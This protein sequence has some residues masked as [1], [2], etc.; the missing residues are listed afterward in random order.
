MGRDQLHLYRVAAGSC[1]EVWAALM[2]AVAWG[3]L[4]AIDLAVAEDLLDLE[5]A[6]LYRMVHPRNV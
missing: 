2:I 5:A 4:A 3:H 1:E 6:M